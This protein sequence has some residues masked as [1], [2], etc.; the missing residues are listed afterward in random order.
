MPTVC[1]DTELSG[2]G[3]NS[4]YT[5]EMSPDPQDNEVEELQIGEGNNNRLT[6]VIE[7]ACS[8]SPIVVT[9]GTSKTGVSLKRNTETPAEDLTELR[10]GK[11]AKN[12]KKQA[13]TGPDEFEARILNAL[14]E[15]GAANTKM[16]DEYDLFFASLAQRAKKLD[17]QVFSK[18]QIDILQLFHNSEFN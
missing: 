8:R 14:E 12:G 4:Q 10:K 3:M 17:R 7:D 2:W 1:N 15:N 5:F 6:R 13:T 11:R 16:E 9:A 18:L